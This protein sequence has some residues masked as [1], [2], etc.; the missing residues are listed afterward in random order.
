MAAAA[1]IKEVK[2]QLHAQGGRGGVWIEGWKKNYADTLGAS[3]REFLEKRPEVVVHALHG[4]KF[5]VELAGGKKAMAKVAAT[6]LGKASA[7]KAATGK[8]ATGK[9]ATGKGASGKGKVAPTPLAIA[10]A[11]TPLA[12][13]SSGSKGWGSGGAGKGQSGKASS[14]GG[15]A[16]ASAAGNWSPVIAEAIR[17]IKEQLFAQGGTGQVWVDNWKSRFGQLGS[18]KD[19]L[20]SRPDKFTLT[21][22]AGNSFLVSLAGSGASGAGQWV[23]QPAEP[24]PAKQ[25]KQQEQ[26]QQQQQQQQ[27]KRKMPWEQGGTAKKQNASNKSKLVTEASTEVEKQLKRPNN[28]EGKVWLKDWG[29]KYAETLGTLREFLESQS[30]KFVVVPGEG[31]KFSVVLTSP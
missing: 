27:Q 10:I 25:K 20:E 1:V 17:E 2:S 3:I 23:W 5:E 21:Y 15:G 31:N 14:K 11:P 28:I 12:S 26:Q 9:A 16:A 24:Q 22:G 18:L 30:D 8:A 19:F 13:A 29:W 6:K 4:S 7:G